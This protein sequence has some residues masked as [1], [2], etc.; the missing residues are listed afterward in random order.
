M[1]Y[2]Y[3]FRIQCIEHWR[4]GTINLQQLSINILAFVHR[5]SPAG[6]RYGD[7]LGSDVTASLHGGYG[8]IS[9]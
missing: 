2:P 7:I 5:I 1:R 6:N 3:S 8:I 9:S 4:S